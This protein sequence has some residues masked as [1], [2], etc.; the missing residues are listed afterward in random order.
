MADSEKLRRTDSALRD[1][2][3]V[4][5]EYEGFLAPTDA[6]LAMQEQADRMENAALEIKGHW[7][8]RTII[9]FL[10]SIVIALFLGGFLGFLLADWCG[11]RL[12][13]TNPPALID[14]EA[15]TQKEIDTIRGMRS[16]KREEAVAKELTSKPGSFAESDP[17]EVKKAARNAKRAAD[18]HKIA[19]RAMNEFPGKPDAAKAMARELITKNREKLPDQTPEA[20]AREVERDVELVGR[21][22]ELKPFELQAEA[23]FPGQPVKKKARLKE[24]LAQYRAAKEK[25]D[26]SRMADRRTSAA[27]KEGQENEASN[28]PTGG[29]LK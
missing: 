18:V 19:L 25:E 27:L 17:K 15:P 6:V 2:K 12:F 3:A 20:F 5:Q 29:D 9:A 22:A 28:S 7:K 11:F 4:H 16:F 26:P 14:G 21:A 13:S 23:E 24:L 8:R 10:I 1:A